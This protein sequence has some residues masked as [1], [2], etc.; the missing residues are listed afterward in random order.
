MVGKKI[1]AI[2]VSILL[3][4]GFLAL[5]DATAGTEPEEMTETTTRGNYP[6]DGYFDVNP[7][8]FAGTYYPGDA[9]SFY[10]ELESNYDGENFDPNSPGIFN[11]TSLF[12]VTMRFDG[13]YHTDMTP[14][15]NDPVIWINNN[16]YNNGGDGY[17]LASKNTTNDFY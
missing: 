9:D 12:N 10:F 4:A 16:V 13:I 5:F 17:F 2:A 8:G 11:S 3:T 14:V 1:M 6:G 15:T 7:Q